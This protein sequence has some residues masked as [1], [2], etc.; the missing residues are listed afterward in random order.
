MPGAQELGEDLL[1]RVL[2]VA[3]GLPL[4][5]EQLTIGALQQL[6]EERAEAARSGRRAATRS[7]VPLSLAELIA[8]RL[9]RL[10]E[11]RGALQAAAALGKPFTADLLA[12]ILDR[13]AEDV[14]GTLQVLLEADIL[15]PALPARDG[16]YEFRHVLLQR[17]AYEAMVQR[18]RRAVHARIAGVL[19]QHP[20]LAGE[21]PPELVAHHLTAAELIDDAVPAWIDAGRQAVRRSAN[22]EAIAHLRR[23]LELTARLPDPATR[24]RHETTIHVT[25]IGPLVATRGFCAPE[26][27]QTCQRGLAL[28]GGEPSPLVFPF[29]N[30]QVNWSLSGGRMPETLTLAE[31]FLALAE[32]S[33]Y[34]PGRVIGYRLKGASLLA[35]GRAAEARQALETSIRLYEP[36]RDESVTYLFGQH[37]R[38][39]SQ[40][41]LSLTLYF[42]GEVEE[43]LALG[44]DT[45]SAADGLR[46]P[47]ST[48]LAVGY[49]GGWV[50]GFCGAMRA[51]Q[52]QAKR[53]VAVSEQHDLPVFRAFGRG[54]LGWALCS[55]G[56]L[57]EG[58][59]LIEGALVDFDA[60]GFRLSVPH[61][62]AILADARRR[63]GQ[64]EEALALCA[65]AR[66][67]IDDRGEHWCEPEVR[68]V[69]ALVASA[70]H[71]DEPERA[72]AMLRDAVACARLYG[73]PSF[74]LRCLRSLLE[75]PGVEPEDGG[76][77]LGRYGELSRRLP[78]EAATAAIIGR[79]GASATARVA[80]AGR[81]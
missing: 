47:L 3:D 45:L 46:H 1:E 22:I 69:E 60:A 56:R 9:D 37:S 62:V 33:G 19:R 18:D 71:P 35:S 66:R 68:R 67:M 48:A 12:T 36:T 34:E 41:I 5:V 26:V 25:L 65:R 2:D 64:I 57:D 59:R 42:L 51:M 20:A 78:S 14:L 17:A 7:S 6:R 72:A 11:G 39:T 27:A 10:P 21:L 73:S 55:E 58:A 28:C 76:A 44:W 23:A 79:L 13:P 74:E 24:A 16:S 43:A 70:M 49:V 77:V 81:L 53:L 50:F 29:L 54:F 75:L 31:R 8:E 4:F 52:A 38:I 30:A 32:G 40:A 15:R 80:Q 61:L 63:T